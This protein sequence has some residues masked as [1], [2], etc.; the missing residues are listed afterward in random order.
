MG[1][2]HSSGLDHSLVLTINCAI[3]RHNCSNNGAGLLSGLINVP[4]DISFA[5]FESDL[6]IA[7]SAWPG[8]EESTSIG[9]EGRSGTHM[10]GED[11]DPTK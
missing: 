1:V 4:Q 8:S 10:W 9:S 6:E 5:Q 3:P 7:T 11:G 2:F